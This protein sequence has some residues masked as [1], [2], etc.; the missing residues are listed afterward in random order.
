MARVRTVRVGDRRYLQVVESQPNGSLSVLQSFGEY[1]LENWLK[2]EQFANSYNQLRELAQT[3]RPT[4]SPD[5]FLPC[6]ARNL[7]SCL[8]GNIS[9]INNRRTVRKECS[10]AEQ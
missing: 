9:R 5:D 2:A 7:R 6:G 8:G 10:E 1:N 3:N 4:G